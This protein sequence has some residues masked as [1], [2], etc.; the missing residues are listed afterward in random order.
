[1]LPKKGTFNQ[2]YCPTRTYR[3]RYA[4]Q[5]K[6]LALVVFSKQKCSLKKEHLINSVVPQGLEP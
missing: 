3:I 4:T 1:M 2:L 6:L 5:H